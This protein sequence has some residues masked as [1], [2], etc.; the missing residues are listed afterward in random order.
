MSRKILSA[1]AMHCFTTNELLEE[2]RLRIWRLTGMPPTLR[3]ISPSSTK[4]VSEN[5]QFVPGANSIGWLI[6]I[7]I[8]SFGLQNA[9][10]FA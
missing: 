3:R 4:F 2:V 1:Q 9:N 7:L 8:S 10:T 5:D 6:P